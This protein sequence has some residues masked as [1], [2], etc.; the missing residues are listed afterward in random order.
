MVALRPDARLQINYADRSVV[1]SVA[2]P[3]RRISGSTIFELGLLPGPELRAALFG[4]LNSVRAARGAVQSVRIIAAAMFVWSFMTALC[5]AAASFSAAADYTCGRGVSEA[6]FTAPASSILG[7]HFPQASG[8][9]FATSIMMLGVPV[10]ALI[11]AVSGGIIAESMGWRWA[12]VIIGA[13]G[14][15]HRV[16]RVAYLAR[17]PPRGHIEGDNDADAVRRLTAVAGCAFEV[18]YSCIV[19]IGGVLGGF[20]IARAPAVA[21][22][23]SRRE[24]SGLSYGTAG[25][26]WRGLVMR[27]QNVGGGLLIGWLSGGP[28]RTYQPEV[29]LAGPGDQGCSAVCRCILLALSADRRLIAFALSCRGGC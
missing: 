4:S 22:G 6:G 13:P 17:I 29:E 1:A 5:G 27:S 24:P 14:T 9:R 20:W 7:D 10:G 11:G 15:S 18:P 19:A 25:L 21:R 3:L 8:A 16:A 23:V 2:E 26:L 12:F 28:H